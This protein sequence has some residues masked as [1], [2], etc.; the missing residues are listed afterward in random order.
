MRARGKL[1]SA[2]T[3]GIQAGEALAQTRPGRPT[4]RRK[5]VRSLAARNSRKRSGAALHISA[6][7]RQ[8]LSRSTV[9]SAPCSQPSDSQIA[10]RILGA[11]S[12]IEVA[13]SSACAATDAALRRRTPEPTA[14]LSPA[15]GTMVKG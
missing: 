15:S 14:P 11:A 12:S 10:C 7:R 5:V 3:S 13:S 6:Q 4:P 2:V 9:Q 8:S 1:P